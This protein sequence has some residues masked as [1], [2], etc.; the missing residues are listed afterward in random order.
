MKKI[1]LLALCLMMVSL[2]AQTPQA[3]KYQSVVRD[4]S[5]NILINQLISMRISILD[6]SATGTAVYVETHSAVTSNYGLVN[7]EI[8]NGVGVQG[9]FSQID[10]RKGNFFVQIEADP[11]GG[12]NYMVL[13]TSQLLSVPYALHSATSGTLKLTEAQR[14]ALQNPE[15]GMMIYNLTTQCLNYRKANS[16]AQLCGECTPPPTPAMAG[17]DTTILYGTTTFLAGNWPAPGNSVLWTIVSGS[18]GIIANAEDP[19]SMFTGTPGNTYVLQYT[20]TN[21]CGSSSDLVTISFNPLP[22]QLYLLGD[23]TPAGWNIDNPIPLDYLAENQFSKTMV[24]DNGP[25]GFKFV[26]TPGSWLYNWGTSETGPI[27]PYTAYPLVPYGGNIIVPDSTEYLIEVDLNTQIFRITPTFIP[28]MPEHLWL[29]GGSTPAGW[30]PQQAIAF[31]QMGPGVFHAYAPLTVA[32]DGFKFLTSPGS[33]EGDWGMDPVNPDSIVPVNEGNCPV[34]QDG[35]YLII[36]DFTTLSYSATLVNWSILGT[37]I[38][39]NSWWEDVNMSYVGGSEPY[40]WQIQNYQI[41]DGEF[42]FRANSSWDINFGDNGNDGLLEN[43]GANIPITAGVYTIKLILE[44]GNWHYQAVPG[45]LNPCGGIQELNYYNQ[46][47]HTV[48]IGNQCWLREN[49]NVGT[50]VQST[51]TFTNHSDCSDNGIIEKYC[52]ENLPS[53]CAIYGGLYD[54]DEMM[55]YNNTPGSQGIC[56]EG[57]HIPTISDYYLLAGYMTGD[58]S[59]NGGLLKETG[60]AHWETPNQGATNATGFKALGAGYRTFLGGFNHQQIEG[61]FWSSTLTSFG[62][63]GVNLALRNFT[64]QAFMLNAL[65]MAGFSVRCIKN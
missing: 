54:W 45:N 31:T 32:G 10:W 62:N 7:L 46:T 15:E 8:G 44:P 47:Y 53:N 37:A 38:S 11:Q 28:T 24:I 9:N 19:T 16:W 55:Q 41:M 30:D 27:S 39:A 29:V 34:L 33:Y 59:N 42:K 25:E 6:G 58:T 49:M 60:F 18:G 48:Q 2:Y 50:M 26:L 52:Y 57:F 13:G 23:A 65:R 43:F 63:S 22:Q 64:G 20:V 5:G 61:D 17:P 36:V 14:D 35:F 12:T 40:T 51:Q 4:G 56:P 21:A 1:I 3:I